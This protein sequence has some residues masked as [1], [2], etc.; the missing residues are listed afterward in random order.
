M[1]AMKLAK[2]LNKRPS[3]AELFATTHLKVGENGQWIWCDAHK[4]S[5]YVS[6]ITLVCFKVGRLKSVHK[7]L[8]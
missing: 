8:I 5:A 2:Q 4:E 7:L 6:T 1:W 3:A